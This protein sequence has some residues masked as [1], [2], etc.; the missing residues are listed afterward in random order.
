MVTSDLARAKANTKGIGKK[1]TKT[2]GEFEKSTTTWLKA[3][4]LGLGEMV[5]KVSSLATTET[6]T[7]ATHLF[8][9]LSV[10]EVFSKWMSSARFKTKDRNIVHQNWR[11]ARSAILSAI[12]KET[13]GTPWN[14]S[15]MFPEEIDNLD[16]LIKEYDATDQKGGD[17]I[18][19]N[20]L[21]YN[22][23]GLAGEIPMEAIEE[24][25]IR[26]SFVDPFKRPNGI[27]RTFTID[28]T[29]VE[30][31]PSFVH[32]E[33]QKDLDEFINDPK[34]YGRW[35]E[36][37]TKKPW[38]PKNQGWKPRDTHNSEVIHSRNWIDLQEDRRASTPRGTRMGRTSA[39]V[40]RARVQR[41]RIAWMGGS[42]SKTGVYTAPDASVTPPPT[43]APPKKTK[44]K[45]K[46]K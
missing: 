9:G 44:A 29:K 17:Y 31:N 38:D 13:G 39:A 5:A 10:D 6:K 35:M 43:V 15:E 2:R 20:Q 25:S 28:L 18:K 42:Y 3:R 12:A 1:L 37:L 33:T 36:T 11:G 27:T 21:L 7:I 46:G 41:A 34:R 26:V 16:K 23:V 45:G 22:F 14:L 19:R 24:G 40:D 32:F 4:D 8:G 30:I